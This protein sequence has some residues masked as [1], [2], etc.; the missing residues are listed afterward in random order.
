MVTR[1]R[2]LVALQVLGNHEFD[3]GVSGLLKP[4]LEQVQFPI[5]SANMVPDHSNPDAAALAA[6]CR[7]YTV[8]TVD[9]H[10]VAVVGYTSRETP[11]L[12]KP[13]GRSR[14]S[15]AAA[16]RTKRSN[17]RTSDPSAAPCR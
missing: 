17:R 6:A 12:S 13:G 3:N 2:P 1:C 5:L 15:T 11:V 7:N 16:P 8:L 10:R 14:T 9:G 4:F